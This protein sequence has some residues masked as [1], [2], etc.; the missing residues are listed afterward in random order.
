MAVAISPAATRPSQR[1][2]RLGG[3]APSA[4]AS[5]GSHTR[6]GGVV[7]VDVGPD[8]AAVADDREPPLADRGRHHGIRGAADRGARTVEAAV[9]Q[10]D[11]FAPFDRGHRPLQIQVAGLRRAQCTGRILNERVGLGQHRPAGA[12]EPERAEALCHDTPR[13]DRAP[14]GQE[15]V[16]RLGAQPVG[17]DHGE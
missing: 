7:D 12:R 1:G 10:R 17:R 9:P 13:P 16:G 6:T 14:G 3:L 11:P 2:T 4:L 5:T 15:V 8:P